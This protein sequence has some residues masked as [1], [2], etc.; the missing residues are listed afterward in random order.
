MPTETNDE[1]DGS[2]DER[3]VAGFGLEW[4]TY[5]QTDRDP[6][7]LVRTFD[8]YFAA[9]PFGDLPENAL[10]L[11]VG[12]GSGRWAE[13]V[14]KQ[15]HNLIGLDASPDALGVA[16]RRLRPGSLVNGS[17]VEI[18][19]VDDSVDFA[20]SLGVLHH[21]PATEAAL[22][23]IRR[24]L[25]P[26][27]PF[28]VYL[29]YAFDNRPAWYR[30]LWKASDVIRQSIARL[31]DRLRLRVTSLV[32]VAVYWPLSRLAK[33]LERL[34]LPVDRI[35]LSAYRD[36]PLYV[37]KTDALDRFGTRL[38]KRYSRAEIESMLVRAGFSDITFNPDWPFWCANAR[39]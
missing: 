15:G 30:L 37:L 17:A 32:G 22:A 5:D 13:L 2:L 4:S 19:L 14:E 11:D 24:V 7:S 21:L 31:P 39:A 23:E 3:T 36:Q 18:P 20:F 38:E 33:V 28:L 10:G 6:E 25:R 29:Y 34:G 1:T 8:R 9:F 35:P 16:Q 27:A 26:G 12:C